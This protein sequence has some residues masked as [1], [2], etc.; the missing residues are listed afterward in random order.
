MATPTL[1]AL[2]QQAFLSHNNKERES[3]EALIQQGM[4]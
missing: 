4:S 3:A 2:I 1:P